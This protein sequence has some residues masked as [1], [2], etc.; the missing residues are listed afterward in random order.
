MV[1]ILVLHQLLNI[2]LDVVGAP[3]PSLHSDSG[4]ALWSSSNCR[5][6]MLKRSRKEKRK[7]DTLRTVAVYAR[8]A[9][10]PHGRYPVPAHP[11][12][13]VKMSRSILALR[14]SRVITHSPVT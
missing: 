7:H 6:T 13:S 11:S 4:L 10:P 1:G 14:S 9:E 12:H 5:D 2:D 8:I 3:R